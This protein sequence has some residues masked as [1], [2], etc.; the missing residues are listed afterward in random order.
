MIAFWVLGTY[1]IVLQ[2]TVSPFYDKISTYVSM[3]GELT[4]TLLG[5][6]TLRKKSDIALIVSFLLI[7]IIS[8]RVNGGSIMLLLNGLRHYIPMM[9]LLPTIRFLL[10]TR[11]RATY[12][13][14]VMDKSLYIFLWLQVPAIVLQCSIYGP[15][16]F[17]GGTFG[18]YQSG[19]I[20]CIIYVISF[21]LMLRRWDF[22]KNYIGN[23][24]ENW[25]LIF[26]LLPT[27]LNETK[28]SFVFLVL[29]FFFLVPMDKKFLMR[30]LVIF[31]ILVILLAGTGY[32]YLKFVNKEEDNP[33]SSQY[34]EDYTLGSDG[35]TTLV[36][37][38]YMNK[39]MPDVYETD[40]ARG[41][42][43]RVTPILLDDNP[44]GWTLGYGV[45]QF[46]GGTHVERTE[47]SE[48]YNW[49][50]QGTLMFGMMIILELGIPGCLWL[51]AYFF[52]VFRWFYK[53]KYRNKRL[54]WFM[55]MIVLIVIAYGPNFIYIS[56]MLP[57][58]YVIFV[59]SRWKLVELV[60]PLP[61]SLSEIL[62]H[63]RL[64][65]MNKIEV[66]RV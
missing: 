60:E 56:F 49:L 54:Q 57:L 7:A 51:L 23:L 28:V 34:L 39:V 53:V 25:I 58:L 22:G 66:N 42:K 1:A 35:M 12:F 8:N 31:P 17:V 40:F 21:Y 44:H 50:F 55:G 14:Y 20:S 48:R 46:K 27:F 10:A 11:E 30:M 65:S 2:E 36:L 5:I 6:W 9:F 13:I 64:K 38:G 4:V 15:T 47:F 33:L 26:L 37:D 19:T 61:L 24:R 52:V 16:D 59:S 63:E 41:L 29:Y 62:E 18:W 32:F 43:F 45:G 3:I